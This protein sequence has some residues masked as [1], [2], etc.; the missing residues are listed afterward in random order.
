TVCIFDPNH[1]ASIRV[2]RKMGYVDVSTASYRGKPTLLM[3]RAKA[4][5]EPESFD[6]CGSGL[7]K[8]S[9]VS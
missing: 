3:E 4:P 8:K 1:A 7:G 2:A 5:L 9:P 6:G